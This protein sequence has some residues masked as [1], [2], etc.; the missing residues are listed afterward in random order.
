MSREGERFGSAVRASARR[1]FARAKEVLLVDPDKRGAGDVGER[2]AAAELARSASELKGG[3]AKVAQLM[4]YL[5]GPG[6]AVDAGARAA[7]G[8][9]WDQAPGADPAAI[10]A[11]VAADLGAPPAQKFAEW[12]DVPL[13]AASLGE[14][15]AATSHEGVA[16]AVKV[17]YPGVA[18]GLRSDLESRRVLERLAGSDVG[19]SLSP[20]SLATLRDAVLRELDY[21]AERK[22]MERFGQRFRGDAQ[23]VVPRTYPELSGARVMSAERLVGAP[24]LTFAAEAGE[25]ERAQ[26]ALTIF[27]F[28][29]AAPLVHKLLNA[30]PNPGNYLVLDGSAGRVGFLDYGCS[31]ELDA[32]TVSS[33]RAL[34]RALVTEEPDEFRAALSRLGLLGRARTLDSVTYREWERYLVA[35]YATDAFHWTVAFARDFAQLTSELVRSGSFAFPPGA[36]LLWRQRLGIASVLGSVGATANYRVVLREIVRRAVLAEAEERAEAEDQR[37]E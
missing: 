11:V 37:A 25:A 21:V 4:A 16:L 36:L 24:L 5:E 6:A 18:E 35:P 1:L 33:D 19:A 7:L 22:A 28:A 12:N 2:A 34:F 15:H 27:R 26:V 31:I 29:Y 14:V 17:Q 13:A 10:R 3:M 23:I 8:A 9:L 32:A 20:E 30:D